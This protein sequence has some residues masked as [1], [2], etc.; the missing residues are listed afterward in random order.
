MPDHHEKP[1]DV[2]ADL[3]AKQL[4]RKHAKKSLHRIPG[5]RDRAR[6]VAVDTHHVGAARVTT[7]V[8]SDI[9]VIIRAAD[10]DCGLDIA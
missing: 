9:I 4:P 3:P 1:G 5:K 2:S 6:S 7:A 8:V 10:D